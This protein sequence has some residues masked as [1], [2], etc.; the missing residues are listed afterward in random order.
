MKQNPGIAAFLYRRACQEA[1]GAY[2]PTLEGA[3]DWDMWLRI[4]ERYPTTVYVP[5]VLYYYRLHGD[6]MTVKQ[7]ERVATASRQVVQHAI[8]RRG[9]LDIEE[10]FPTLGACRDR[11]EAEL[12]ACAEF[13]TALLQSPW[14][15]PRSRGRLPRRGVL[16][17][18]RAGRGRQL[19]HR[20]RASR[21]LRPRSA[22]ASSSSAASRTPTYAAW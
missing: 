19:R 7:R 2:D 15:P 14:A 21:A 6:S 16:G 1:V 11:G 22:A 17:P 20:E 12:H 13:G 3:E 5:E 10:L 18:P 4:V 8:A 9:Q